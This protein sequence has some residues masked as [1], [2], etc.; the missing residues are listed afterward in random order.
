MAKWQDP[1]GHPSTWSAEVEMLRRRVAE[2]EDFIA[3]ERKAHEKEIACLEENYGM[4]A[5]KAL[6]KEKGKNDAN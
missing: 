1:I 2:L 4:L 6:K 5:D 3:K